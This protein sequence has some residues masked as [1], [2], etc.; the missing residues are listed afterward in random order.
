LIT[1][2]ADPKDRRALQINLT[3]KGRELKE[4]LTK[5]IEETNRKVLRNLDEASIQELRHILHTIAPSC[6]D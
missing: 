5:V 1:K 4:P 3:E 2:Q 6:T